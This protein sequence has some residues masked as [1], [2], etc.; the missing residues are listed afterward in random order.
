MAEPKKSVTVNL[1]PLMALATMTLLFAKVTGLIDVSWWVVA[2]PILAPY[3]FILG[4]CI[5][6]LPVIAVEAMANNNT[7]KEK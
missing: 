1:F 4:A 6:A 3:V 7:S 5:A 2:M